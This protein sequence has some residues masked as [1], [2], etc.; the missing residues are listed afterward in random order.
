MFSGDYMKPFEDEGDTSHLV[1]SINV[2]WRGWRVKKLWG[3]G[4]SYGLVF[5]CSWLVTAMFG[6]EVFPLFS[7]W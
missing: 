7:H 4:A 3:E 1:V 6:I 2:T 5:L